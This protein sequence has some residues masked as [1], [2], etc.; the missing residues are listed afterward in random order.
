MRCRRETLVAVDR[1]SHRLDRCTTRLDK[2]H[3]MMYQS[4]RFTVQNEIMPRPE[5]CLVTL[6]CEV[7]RVHTAM[8]RQI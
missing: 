3:E 8:D 2:V 7:S 5:L 4:S 1:S 6:G